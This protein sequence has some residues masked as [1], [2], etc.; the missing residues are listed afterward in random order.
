[1]PSFSNQ[2]ET[3]SEYQN[4]GGIYG[5]GQAAAHDDLKNGRLFDGSLRFMSAD[6]RAGYQDE[7]NRPKVSEPDWKSRAERAEAEVERL[8]TS[9]NA[10]IDALDNFGV[11]ASLMHPRLTRAITES[12]K[13]LAKGAESCK[14]SLRGKLV[15]DG[16]E[17]CNPTLA[18][19]IRKQ[20]ADRKGMKA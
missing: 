9:S 13:A 16:C 8:R 12:R 20:N 15:G 10:L 3:M 18:E 7:W 19:E 2:P 5:D 1:M 11:G 17:V 14:C 4:R 6:Y